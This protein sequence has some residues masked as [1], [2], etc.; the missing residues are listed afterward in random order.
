MQKRKQAR[1]VSGWSILRKK[2]METTCEIDV[3]QNMFVMNFN[4][5]QIHGPVLWGLKKKKLSPYLK[6]FSEK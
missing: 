6:E 4:Q 5:F 2:Q 1:W 3:P